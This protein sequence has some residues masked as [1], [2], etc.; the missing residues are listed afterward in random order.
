MQ[1]YAASSDPAAERAPYYDLQRGLRAGRQAL[2]TA[3]TWGPELRRL[4]LSEQNTGL[5]E[6]LKAELYELHLVMVQARLQTDDVADDAEALLKLLDRAATFAKPTRSFYRLR[7]EC[8]DRLGQDQRATEDRR[9]AKDPRTPTTALDHFLLGEHYRTNAA[10]HS[11]DDHSPYDHWADSSDPW[12]WGPRHTPPQR[13]ITE[14]RSAL[15]KDPRHFWAH[16]QLGRCLLGLGRPSD[17][18][19]AL[20]TCVALKP[21]SP[22]GY[23]ARG[24][25]W[26]LAGDFD[27]A[28]EDFAH[29]SKNHPEFYPARL[30]RGVAY[31]LNDRPQKAIAEFN[32]VLQA[33]ED[34]R[35][36]EAALYRGQIYLESGKYDQAIQDFD[37]VIEQRPG[38]AAAYRNRA[39]VLLLQGKHDRAIDDINTFLALSLG[40]QFDPDSPEAYHQ[41][42]RFL[43]RYL[44]PR[45]PPSQRNKA[46]QWAADEFSAASGRG[47]RSAALL[48]DWGTAREMLGEFPAALVVFSKGLELDAEHVD[49]RIERGIVYEQDGKHDLAMADFKEAV[50]VDPEN[51]QAITRRGYASAKKRLAAEAEHDAVRALLAAKAGPNLDVTG[52]GDYFVLHNVACIY[53]ELSSEESDRKEAYQDLAMKL[54]RRALEL[55]RLDDRSHH[56][57]LDS[58]RRE[59]A[60]EPLR[61]RED[62]Q[63]LFQ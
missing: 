3:K 15:K 48:F 45:V 11:T 8:A 35:L 44:R 22:W 21:G 7:A 40:D 42:G 39:E 10:D 13:A 25:A 26:A 32:A 55:W 53:A 29:L 27:A 51:A 36:I 31:W 17:A 33:P 62:F 46:A 20:G 6:E 9:R 52:A 54:I 34:Q 57:E 2:Q 38:L 12:K 50:R 18:V 28:Q 30:N 59:P 43:L 23:N 16:L 47:G 4:V 49:L 37:R 63:Q 1:F 24:L 60:F 19:E 61:Q 58:I 5:K 56:D 14:Y 41:R